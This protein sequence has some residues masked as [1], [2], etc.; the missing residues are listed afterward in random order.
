ME[1]SQGTAAHPRSA[2]NPRGL[3]LGSGNQIAKLRL[4]GILSQ[5]WRERLVTLP[6]IVMGKWY[7]ASLT[8]A[9]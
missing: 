5:Q 6:P 4:G 1:R 8:I 2:L 7:Q 9:R 3:R